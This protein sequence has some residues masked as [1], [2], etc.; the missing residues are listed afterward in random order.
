MAEFSLAFEDGGWYSPCTWLLPQLSVSHLKEVVLKKNY[1]GGLRKGATDWNK[2]GGE[3]VGVFC[4]CFMFEWKQMSESSLIPPMAGQCK[5]EKGKE[6]M[7]RLHEFLL[8]KLDSLR[9]SGWLYEL[10]E[11]GSVVC[12]CHER[13]MWGGKKIKFC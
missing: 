1:G 4:S 13:L 6:S 10:K 11:E 2:E 3:N 5:R 7:L 8:A 9:I 12:V